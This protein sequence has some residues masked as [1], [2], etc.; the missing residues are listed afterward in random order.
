MLVDQARDSSCEQL[1][2]EVSVEQVNV[3][4]DFWN[5]ISIKVGRVDAG[6]P[7]DGEVLARPAVLASTFT[8]GSEG[9]ER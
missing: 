3:Y 5:S 8:S 6:A 9:Q 2:Q 4:D 1:V 7:D